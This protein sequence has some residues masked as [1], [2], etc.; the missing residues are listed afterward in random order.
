MFLFEWCF[1]SHSRIF[2]SYGD[3]W[4][5]GTYDHWAV[6]V[7]FSVP[8]LLWQEASVYNGHLRGPVKLTLTA[9]LLAVE[10]SQPVFT[11]SVFRGWDSNTQPSACG[12]NTL[13]HC[14]T[15][16]IYCN[17]GQWLN[18]CLLFYVPF[19]KFSLPRRRRH[20]RL[21]AAD[22]F[23]CSTL[24]VLKERTVFIVPQLLWQEVIYTKHSTP[25][26]RSTFVTTRPFSLKNNIPVNLIRALCKLKIPP[27]FENRSKFIWLCHIQELK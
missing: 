25:K 24:T 27:L 17:L 23:Q 11:T 7:F 21:R 5:L 19:E 16:A 14:A 10:L 8:H 1:S 2:H 3:V 18:D 15:S 12:A 13:T 4:V 6:R 9:K 26:D 20:Y 22:F